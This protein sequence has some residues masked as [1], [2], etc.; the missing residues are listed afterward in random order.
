MQ[1]RLTRQRLAADPPDIQITPSLRQVLL[2][3]F[4]RA[5]EAI[6]EGERATQAIL[7]MIKDMLVH[8]SPG[9]GT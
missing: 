4:H 1:D 6:T 9:G 8:E 2:W 5:D 7:P 3:E